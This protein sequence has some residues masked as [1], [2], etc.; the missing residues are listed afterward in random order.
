[1][2]LGVPMDL[3]GQILIAMPGM[4]DPRFERSVVLITFVDVAATGKYEHYVNAKAIYS[5]DDLSRLMDGSHGYVVID[6]MAADGRLP[7]ETIRYI[8]SHSGRVFYDQRHSYS[9][10]WVYQF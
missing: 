6:S 1:M 4:A 10:I 3:A 7:E 2:S 5:L 8:Q 9:Q